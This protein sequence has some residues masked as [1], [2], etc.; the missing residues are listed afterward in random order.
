MIRPEFEFARKFIFK[1]LKLENE[2]LGNTRNLKN[3][4]NL[5][6]TGN[7]ENKNTEQDELSP[8]GKKWLNRFT[9]IFGVY[10]LFL[11]SVFII[12]T[13]IL[14]KCQICANFTNFMKQFIPSIEIFGSTS[15]IPQVVMF[16]VSYISIISVI[17]FIILLVFWTFLSVKYNV[18]YFK[19]LREALKYNIYAFL[20]FAMSFWLVKKYFS[21]TLVL[22]KIGIF[23]IDFHPTMSSRLE[24][25][26]WTFQIQFFIVVLSGLVFS[27]LF[28]TII[29]NIKSLINKFF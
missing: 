25:L 27:V 26:Y 7:S 20:L 10:I 24:I 12:P 13:D 19:N 17:V 18:E 23:A 14:D 1:G 6:N 11:L 5:K 4:E 8:E 2:N 28:S 16:Y 9:F 3:I 22:E 15:K 21:G 29:L